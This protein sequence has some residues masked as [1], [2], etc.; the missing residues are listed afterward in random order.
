VRYADDFVIVFTREDDARRV[1][2]VLPKRLAR[3]GLT[4]H[5][6]KTRL[7]QF[8]PSGPGRGEPKTFDFLGFTHFWAEA[9]RDAG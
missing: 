6:T 3:Y 9:G 4:L 8:R 7:L 1:L 5:P 2:D